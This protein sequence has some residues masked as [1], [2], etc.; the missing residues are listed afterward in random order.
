MSPSRV[1]ELP[2]LHDRLGV[3]ADRAEAGEV[4]AGMLA[5]LAAEQ[6][7]VLAIPAGGLPV[8]VP[9]ARRLGCPLEVAVVSKITLPW[10]SEAGYGAVAFDGTVRLNRE[11]AARLPLSPEQIE[12][13]IAAT[14]AKVQR[15][16][17]LFRGERPLPA[18]A[19]RPVILIDDGLASGFTLLTAVAALRNQGADQLIVAVPTGHEQALALVAPLVEG[20]YCANVRG[21]WS[22]AVAAAYRQW[23]DVEE[24]EVL[25][26]LRA[27]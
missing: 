5:G 10:N 23:E 19:G 9:L 11:L 12:A 1:I 21:G 13:G 7:L 2:E 4:L 8:A 16:V 3:F 26:L 24:A 17:K 22:F 14:R 18:L 27:E 25:R 20:L 15:R 6:P